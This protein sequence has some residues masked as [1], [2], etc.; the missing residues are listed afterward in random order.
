[1]TTTF[2]E[3]DGTTV[4]LRSNDVGKDQRVTDNGDGTST[5]TAS[6]AGGFTLTGPVE[7]PRNPGRSVF[8]L[9][10]DTNGTPRDPSDDEVVEGSFEVVRESTGLNETS[11]DCFD[12][13]VVTGRAD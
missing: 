13:L 5:I 11:D 8:R 3:P 6:G 4:V 1:M 2:S 9:D 10:V 12:Y 7:R